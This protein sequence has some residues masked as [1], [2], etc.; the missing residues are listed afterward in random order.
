MKRY[1]YIPATHFENS[2]GKTGF[3]L[4]WKFSPFIFLLWLMLPVTLFGQFSLPAIS[5]NDQLSKT[6]EYSAE[7]VYRVKLGSNYLEDGTLIAYTDGQMRGAQTA[8]VLFPPT[9]T[10]VFKVR[11]FSNAVREENITF[12]YYDVFNKKIYDI[13][14]KATFVADS[15]TDYYHPGL[16]N[17]YCGTVGK[18]TGLIPGDATA[19]QDASDVLYWQPADNAVFYRLFLWKEGDSFPS[20][21]YRDNIYGTHTG[22]SNL[23]YGSTY[24]WFVTSVNQCTQDTS[25]VN[26]FSVR[27]LPDLMITEAHAPDTVVSATPF[28][29]AY[30]VSNNGA[31]ATAGNDWKDAFY[32][33]SDTVLSSDDLLIDQVTNTQTLLPDSDRVRNVTGILPKEY[34]G[35]Y[36]LF[37][38]SD[39]RNNVREKDETNNLLSSPLMLTVQAKPLPDISVSR[40]TADKTDVEPGDTLTVS[41]YVENGGSADAAGGWTEKVSLLS[42]SGVRKDLGVTPLYPGTLEKGGAIARSRTFVLPTLLSFAGKTELRVELYPSDSLV[43]M[44]GGEANN[45]GVSDDRITVQ[46]KLS[47]LLQSP[48][49]REDYSGQIR[50]Y[51]SRSGN[52][53]DELTVNLRASLPGIINLPATVTIP[54]HSSS[55]LFYFSPVDNT[56]L[57]GRRHITIAASAMGFNTSQTALDI[58]DDEIPALTVT[59]DSDTVIEGD[60]LLLTLALNLALPDTIPLYLSTDQTSQWMFPSSV[61][62]PANDPSVQ[63]PVIVTDDVTPELNNE[64][65]LTVRSGNIN[66]G[67]TSVF[68]LDNDIPPI[69]MEI[70]TDS[71]SEEDGPYATWGLIRREGESTCPIR[72]NLSADTPNALYFPSYVELKEGEKQ[73]QFNIGVIDNNLVDG[74]RSVTLTGAIY[75]SSCGCMTTKNNGG[76][77]SSSVTVLDNDGPSLSVTVS[78]ASLAEGKDDAGIMSIF[79]N[80]STDSSLTVTLFS[81]DTGELTLP[82]TAIIPAGKA[83]V[84]VTIVTEDDHTDDGSQMVTLRAAAPGFTPGTGWVYVTD[85]NRPDLEISGLNLSTD[86]V[87]T[88]K[89][90]E[91]QAEILNNGYGTAPSG[92]EIG[93]YLSKDDRLDDK[94][95]LFYTATLSEPVSIGGS[96]HLMEVITAPAMPGQYYLLTKVN[97]GLKISE[98]VYKN[99]ISFAVPLTILPG[100]TGTAVAEEESFSKPQPVAIH[101]TATLRNGVHAAGVMLDIYVINNDIRRV[102]SVTTDDEGHFTTAFHPYDYESGHY[103]VGACYPGELSREAQDS[104][105]I[106]GMER[107]SDEYF[108]WNLKRDVPVEG[109]IEIKNRSF[110]PLHNI[111][112]QPAS[113]P[114]GCELMFDTLDILQGNGTSGIRYTVRGLELTEGAHYLEF[115]MNIVSSEGVS[116]EFTVYYYCQALGSHLESSPS[117]VNTTVTKGKTRIYDLRIINNGAGETRRLN[118]D[119]PDVPW[120]SMVSA[121]TLTTLPAGD[122]MVLSLLL[123]SDELPLNTPVSGNFAVHVTN[124]DDL[125]IPFRIEVVSEEKGSLKVDVVDEYTYFTGEAPHLANAHVVVRHPFS[126]QI[127]AEGFTD[128][129]GIFTADSLPEGPCTITVDAEKHEGA[130]KTVMIDPGRVKTETVFLSF[131]A[132]T[133]TWEVVPTEIEDKYDIDLVMDFETNVPVPVLVME[134]P[135]VMPRL[136]ADETFSFMVTL[137]NKG[138]ITAEDVEIFFP[139]D[140]P[141]YEWVFNFPKQSLLA[142]QSIQ[143]PVVLKRKDTGKS[144]DVRETGGHK[145]SGDGAKSGERCADTGG[146]LYTFECGPD[147]QIHVIHVF[148]EYEGRVCTGSPA[149][150]GG[151]IAAGGPGGPGG[152]VPVGWNI[153]PATGEHIT[154]CDP[155]LIPLVSA[156]AG[157]I[158]GLGPLSCALGAMDGIDW[159]DIAGCFAP[160]PIG[161]AMGIGSAALTCYFGNGGAPPGGPPGMFGAGG[162]GG[163]AARK[164]G[165]K[166]AVSPILEQIYLDMAWALTHFTTRETYISQVMGGIDWKNKESFMDFSRAIDSVVTHKLHFD[167]ETV[168]R[169]KQDMQGMDIVPQEIDYFALRWN[170]SMDAWSQGILSPNEEFPGI[171]DETAL[172]SCVQLN[173]SAY[174]YSLKRGYKNV[175]DMF[176][177]AQNDYKE[178]LEGKRSAVC[179]SVTIKISQKLVM[180]REAFEGTLT[181]FNGNTTTGMEGIKL[182]LEVRN[183]KGELCNDL[184]QIETKAMDILT[185]IDGHGTLGAEEKGSAT[186]LFIPEKGAAPEVPE[187]YS[188]GGSFSYV[189]PFT[190]TTVTRNLL[191]VTLE[192]SPSPDLFLHYFM[193]RNIFGD[194]PLTD[195]VEPIIPAELAV[196]V[197]NNGYGTAKKVR[198][199]SAQPE[200]VD[201]EKGLAIHFELT[202]SNLNGQ[203]RQLG[204]TDIDFGN[205]SPRTATIG[206]WW[207]TSDLMGHFVNYE[208]HLSHLDS[209]GN[210]DLSLVSGARLHE[211]IRSIRVYGGTDDGI[212]DF[213]VNEIQDIHERPDA[214]YLSQGDVIL[215]V[216][217]ADAGVFEGNIQAPDFTDTLKVVASKLG[218]NYV[219]LDDPGH[220]NYRIV[221]ITR[222]DG[223]VIPVENGWLTHVTL[224]DGRDPVYENKFHFTDFFANPGTQEYTVVWEQKPSR[225]LSVVSMEGPAGSVVSEQVTT[226]TVTFSTPVDPA[227]FDWHDLML[228]Q[229]GGENLLDAATVIT[230]VDSVTYSVDISPFTGGDGYYVFTVQTSEITDIN[231]FAGEV[232]KQ[233]SWSQF[234]NAPLVEEFIGIPESGSGAPFDYLLVRFNLPIDVYTMKASRFILSKDGTPVQG[235]LTI[236]LMD[237]EARLFRISGLKAMMTQDGRYTLTVDLPNIATAKGKK[238]VMQQTTGWKIDTTPPDIVSFLRLFDG[239]LDAQHTTAIHILFSEPVRG[240]DLSALELWKDGTRQPL[241]QIHIDTLTGNAWLL[242]GFRML[243]YYPGD[244]TLQVD[245]SHVSDSAHLNGTELREYRWSVDRNLPRQVE[246]L[247]IAPDLGFSDTDGITSE[248]DLSVSMEITDTSV[249]KIEI[250]RNIPGSLL[251]LADTMVTGSG[252]Y[253]VPVSIPAA[254]TNTIE[255]H[256][257]NRY[258]NFS[259]TQTYIYIDQAALH[260]S[261]VGIPPAQAVF[262]PDTIYLVLSEKIMED[263]LQKSLFSL[264]N[265]GAPVDISRLSI[266]KM[267]DTLYRITGFDTAG[268]GPGEY[269]FSVDLTNTHKYISGLQGNYV[270]SAS[271]EIQNVNKSPVADAG[272][273]FTAIRGNSYYLDGSSSY[274][275]D[276]D[277]L[278]FEWFAPEGIVLDDRYSMTPSFTVP[279]DMDTTLITF[280]LLVSDGELTSTARI[281][282]F[283]TNASDINNPNADPRVL[284]YPNPTHDHL[285]VEVFRTTVRYVRILDMTGKTIMIRKW[286]GENKESFNLSFLH[287]G[288]YFVKLE[289]EDK[290]LIRKIM[291]K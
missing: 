16:L 221:S 7:Y 288:L 24:H 242:S 199:E 285:T 225:V 146:A 248:T 114:E 264:T 41:W 184:F 74:Y 279:E 204:L 256:A 14:E 163:H 22:V 121:D 208:T 29:V 275:P 230:P 191:P 91:I 202:G 149:G 217:G 79:R 117:S 96:S 254:G 120:M 90:L 277:E 244:Y 10:M 93:F 240:L 89:P 166:G 72:V 229:Q 15:V 36:Y 259:T 65:M 97:P 140:D 71:I 66:A 92:A 147:R 83:S 94:D 170:H 144:A 192:V 51:V 241:S 180:T 284:I 3:Y 220:G 106:L 38:R 49:V 119:L 207:F 246:N 124:G 219:E 193:Q 195:P 70:L 56:L 272:K 235:D 103:I 48:V 164:S 169:V 162:K 274:D 183:E 165:G 157:C 231:G 113:L 87:V 148:F 158:P 214:I 209:R 179:A 218:W 9:N 159:V 136:T 156:T 118:I 108:I 266:Q 43:E 60:T 84:Q 99:N 55:A 290:T 172:D 20:G 160:P 40:I 253:S 171:I 178:F 257:L 152:A 135:K 187:S 211:L 153:P 267:A 236:T 21:P 181:I 116:F 213:L 227:T 216:S 17:A 122:T 238:G 228:R 268:V 280:L 143:I 260:A 291:I 126:G 46:S 182:N 82:A 125:S 86:T 54:T 107:A 258:D 110:V 85:I 45:Q 63:V 186:I 39:F 150:F 155:C 26:T 252:T 176:Q 111:T 141:A 8:S 226:V 194:D 104:F 47:V 175:A 28:V 128:A 154:G 12:R 58:T 206:Q 189:D 278:L 78:P 77:V 127:L 161:C 115:P 105:D 273:D 25:A 34:A 68:I 32:L 37:I 188:F 64:A 5:S 167:P 73:K 13:T 80:T 255:V 44:P 224:P 4:P 76:I 19:N 185:G 67:K 62:L 69:G 33:S 265:N 243:T 223:Q 215:D 27:E 232:G 237:N 142:Q 282:V 250:Y 23:A 59:F 210:P 138:L 205:I 101:G 247:R 31:G 132:I 286:T 109:I 123:T 233:L 151:P 98:L 190:G 139:K 281:N 11:I 276:N 52:A 174:H 271:W 95:T 88:K 57:N 263:P 287:P 198:I 2:S 261:W 270:A 203:P 6:F 212:Q 197:V 112:L 61:I 100:Y 173:D 102:W 177:Q 42:L 269:I 200:I 137:T 1:Q 283:L 289:T 168:I 81:G 222:N 131:Q 134:M 201:N 251:L 130:Q 129:S 18:P 30:T 50:G 245:M 239:G 35:T 53:G 133:Y 196:M 234:V 145:S 249:Q 262:H 75:L